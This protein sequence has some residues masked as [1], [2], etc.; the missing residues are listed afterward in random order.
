MA[1]YWP[2][3]WQD[4]RCGARHLRRN[5][6]FAAVAALSAALGIGACSAIF[7]IVNFAVFRPLPVAEPD[8]LMT[9]TG[10]KR[11]VAGGSMSYPEV[12][13]LANR[14]RSWEAVAAFSPFLRAGI[15]SGEVARRHWGFL[16]T[17]N[18]FDVV[19]PNFAVGRGFVH[20]DDDIPGAPAKIVL[21]HGL[22]VSRFG[23]DPT[24]VGRTIRVNKRAMTVVGV[25][26]AGFR[27]SEVGIAADFFL[28]FSQISE[29][30]PLKLSDNLGRLTDYNAQWLTGLGR[31]RPGLDP[32]QARAEME[33][34]AV[35]I[36]ASAPELPRDR[37]FYAERA[38]QVMPFLRKLA[39][40]AFLLLLT[41][42]FLVL[43]TA[44]ANVANLMLA[45]ASA[46]GREIA[47]R[48]AVG[49]SRGRL[50]RQ[51]M[52]ESLMLAIGGGV[53]GVALAECAGR[54]IAGLRLPLPVPID[55][56][57]SVDYRVVLFSTA[58]SVVTGIA[59]GLVPAFRATRTDLAAS[60]RSGGASVAGLRRFGLRNS[61]VVAQVG[62]SGVLVICSGLFLRSLD[63]TR[64]IDSG[65]NTKN[66]ALVEFDPSLSRYDEKQA[67]RLVLDVLRDAESLPGVRTASVTNL[68]PLSVGG[69]FT[70][71]GAQ[72]ERAAVMAV[73]PRYFETMGIPLLEGAEFRPA[74]STEP[75]AIV[76]QELARRLY[77][78]QNAVGRV[79]EGG[80]RARIVGVAANSKYQTIQESEATP[81]L[82]R[83]ILDTYAAEGALGGLTL[84][85]RSA[86]GSAP[87]GD[88]IR[89]AGP[90]ARSGAG[91]EPGRDNGIAPARSDVPATAGRHAVRPVRGHGAADR[92]DWDLR[93]DQL[94]GGAADSRNRHPH[95]AG[96]A[97]E[98]GCRDGVVA[99]GGGGA[100]WD[101]DRV[102]RRPCA[103]AGGG[104]PPL[105]REHDRSG[106]VCQRAGGAPGRGPAGDGDPGP[107]RGDGGP[108]PDAAGGVGTSVCDGSISPPR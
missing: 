36:R 80:V 3:F 73:G 88:M 58:L 47:T 62:L 107:P 21:T 55:L 77:P 81:I 53:L 43:M 92:L 20:G 38:G 63:A 94:C 4:L 101:C 19:R 66:L 26:G 59:F 74:F 8:R 87:P 76:N 104:E 57:L 42:T 17:A 35:G 46:R 48:L 30:D 70:R 22:W 102:S 1:R 95:G 9:I 5:P 24:I 105:W 85:I 29:L 90:A 7:T 10:L 96:R 32:R 69:N 16:V 14:T 13:D 98:P 72:D 60:I 11:G 25:T 54:Y 39:I 64:G 52:T 28:P 23:A 106:D 34:A 108:K 97:G 6:G 67:Q 12:R 15:R 93:R 83:P 56:A 27:G 75:V 103:G 33:T 84:M 68:L 31:L 2:D 51:L 86:Q 99:R 37:R 79:L 89:Q 49:A 45:R 40:P 78:N 41:V 18:Y 61:L 100:G 50:I 65:M 44:C 82:Y 71:V 91:G